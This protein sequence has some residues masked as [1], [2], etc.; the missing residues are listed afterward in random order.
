M[1]EASICKLQIVWWY[2]SYSH[3]KTSKTDTTWL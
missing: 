3:S 2:N 1:T